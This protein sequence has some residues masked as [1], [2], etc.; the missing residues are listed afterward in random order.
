L[1]ILAIACT[2][3]VEG[4][5]ITMT[6][7]ATVL[8]T[9]AVSLVALQ[10][11]LARAQPA[12]GNPGAARF[13]VA[14]VRPS[15]STAAGIIG[16]RGSGYEARNG[17]LR[18]L[19]LRAYDLREFQ[20]VCGEQWLET[21]RFDL[22]ARADRSLGPRLSRSTADC[23]SRASA[24]D[25][26]GPCRMRGSFMRGGGTLSGIGQPLAAIAQQLSSAVD[27]IVVDRSGLAGQFDYD[28]R[29]SN[30]GLRATDAAADESPGIFTAV[31]EQLGLRLD[32][33]RGPVDVVVID[34]AERPS[35]D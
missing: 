20:L 1:T 34:S 17:P 13:E 5:V 25:E 24:S 8:A 28:L 2:N 16:P 10:P 31:Q 27:R 26:F 4:A 33:S 7:I 29:W 22:V 12:A 15:S 14:S 32:P 30:A 18:P 35:P 6:T 19:I 23:S 3:S 11:A 9:S 21:E